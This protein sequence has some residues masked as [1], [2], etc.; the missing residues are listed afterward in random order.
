M[1]ARSRHRLSWILVCAVLG[2]AF[3]GAPANG[4]LIG[5]ED[6]AAAA[7]ADAARDRVKALAQRPEIARQL[8]ALGIAPDQAQ[9]RVGAM[10]DAEVLAL[11]GRLDSLP[12]AGALSNRDLLVII[13]VIV[14]L[15]LLL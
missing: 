2:L 13:L 8:Q 10:T 15:A 4:G 3:P 11:A 12:A 9:Q 14:L 6:A 5:T 7:Q 1:I